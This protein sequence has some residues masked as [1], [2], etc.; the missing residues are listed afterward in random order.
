MKIGVRAHDYGRQAIESLVDNITKDG[1]ESIQLAVT[2]V[3]EGVN[4]YFDVDEVLVNRINAACK[5]KL[6]IAVFGCYIDAAVVDETKRL[7][8]V[9]KFLKGIELAKAVG[10]GCI[11]TETTHFTKESGTR[12]EAFKRLLDTV[13]RVVQKAEDEGVDIGIEPVVVHTLY[14]PELTKEL[15][16]TIKSD[17]LKVIFDPV[18]L[19]TA[20]NILKQDELWDRSFTMFGE[21]ICAMHFKGIQLIDGELQK[22]E[23]VDSEVHYGVLLDWMKKYK[24]E[25]SVLR[26]EA[27]P[28]K[29]KEEYAFMAQF[30]R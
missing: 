7:Q 1:Y 24:P 29:G 18:N 30:V 2:K 20:E 28:L 4:S 26:E 21:K 13:S 5:G 9:R 14:S 11:G 15:I 8:E 23:L 6:D 19:L 10:A 25:I 16:D 22:A 17:R 12:D 3:L 27:N